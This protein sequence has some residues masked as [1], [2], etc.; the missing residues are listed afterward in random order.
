MPTVLQNPR[1]SNTSGTKWSKTRPIS[2][3][4]SGQSL[5]V[6][7]SVLVKPFFIRLPVEILTGDNAAAS[8]A[9]HHMLV[10]AYMTDFI[11]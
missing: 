11:L 2:R 4:L 7:V 9:R 8:L 1:R 6:E 10:S 5:R 3:V